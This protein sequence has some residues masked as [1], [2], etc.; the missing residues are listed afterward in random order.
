[1]RRLVAALAGLVGLLLAA[2][3]LSPVAGRRAR[4]VDH[5]RLRADARPGLPGVRLRAPQRSGLRRQLRQPAAQ[6]RRRSSSGRPT[7]R[8]CVRGRARTGARPP[9]RPGGQPDPQGQAGAAR[10]VDLLGAVA[11]RRDREVHPRRPAARRRLAQLRDLG[12]GRQPAGH[13]LRPGRDLE[14]APRRHRLEVVRLA[15]PAGPRVRHH[16]HRLPARSARRA[17]HPAD[18]ARRRHPADQRRALPG[19]RH[20]RRAGPVRSRRCGPRGPPSSRTA[21]ASAAPATS[22]SR[23]PGCPH[24]WSSSRPPA[25][26]STASPTLPLTGDNGSPIPF[27][28]PCSATFLGTKVLVANQSAIFGDAGHQAILAVEVG[29]R[30]RAPYLPKQARFRY[31]RRS[32]DGQP[33]RRHGCA[34]GHGRQG[35]DGGRLGRGDGPGRGPDR[36]D[37]PVPARGDRQRARLPAGRR[38]RLPGVPATAGRRARPGRRPG[39]LP[40][41]GPPDRPQLR[42]RP[43]TSGR[44][45]GAWSTSTS[46]CATTPASC[47]RAAAT[48]HRGATRA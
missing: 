11:R 6:A 40:D 19:A 48:S 29:E 1:M 12:A 23:W 25:R 35:A 27:D 8:C 41:A 47:R 33:C 39:P 46:S 14:G 5:H 13:R 10:D 44:C 3:L 37:G 16:R 4:E 30:G 34:R 45:R 24:S 9:R 17:D 36:A 28:T 22:T 38:P 20:A 42:R 7:A 26:S 21:S 31:R 18:H 32:S 43:R 2:T 15:P